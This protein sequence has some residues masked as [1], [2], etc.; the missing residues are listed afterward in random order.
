[1]LYS[2]IKQSISEENKMSQIQFIEAGVQVEAAQ[3][4]G[5]M[6]RSLSQM[7]VRSV[8]SLRAKHEVPA[9]QQPGAVPQANLGKMQVQ[10]R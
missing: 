8:R 7:V 3:E 2:E 6:V 9:V 4:L 1:M 5:R 10:D